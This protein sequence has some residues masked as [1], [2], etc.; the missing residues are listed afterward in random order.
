MFSLSP[1]AYYKT[2]I[3][4]LCWFT[5]LYLNCR[6]VFLTI[7]L[8]SWKWCRY[9]K[10]YINTFKSK[11]CH[12][13]YREFNEKRVY[14]C[15]IKIVIFGRTFFMATTLYTEFII[16]HGVLVMIWRGKVH[17]ITTMQAEQIQIALQ[18]QNVKHRPKF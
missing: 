18:F 3:I 11:H 14:I 1:N 10:N 16:P 9:L 4:S 6:N 2:K 15:Y 17:L 12:I 8:K 13:H 7:W 5:N